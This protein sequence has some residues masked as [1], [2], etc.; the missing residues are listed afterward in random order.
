MHLLCVIIAG[1]FGLPATFLRSYRVGAFE[2][3]SI[4]FRSPQQLIMTTDMRTIIRSMQ[5]SFSCSVVL[6]KLSQEGTERCL[7]PGNISFKTSRALGAS[8][9]DRIISQVIPICIL[10]IFHW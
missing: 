4:P 1:P 9:E 7:L 8:S 2:F 5:E 6:I 10:Q 3:V